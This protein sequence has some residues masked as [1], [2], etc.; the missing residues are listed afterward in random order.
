MCC[1]K[2]IVTLARHQKNNRVIEPK[3]LPFQK[4]NRSS[5]FGIAM[6]LGKKGM[7]ELS[8][9]GQDGTVS[10]TVFIRGLETIFQ[11]LYNQAANV[12]LCSFG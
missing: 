12:Q 11:T 1:S 2:S 6:E 7:V 5:D 8:R 3:E 4:N 10:G 9:T